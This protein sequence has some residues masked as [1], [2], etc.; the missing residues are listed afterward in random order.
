MNAPRPRHRRS[1][2][3]AL[4]AAA[5]AAALLGAR[6]PAPSA[7]VH[8]ADPG[9]Q[10]GGPVR[11]RL[12]LS[13]ALANA[14]D[15]ATS[16]LAPDQATVVWA[17]NFE[18]AW[19]SAGWR[20]FD[21]DGAANGDYQWAQRCTGRAGSRGA[22]GM[23]GGANGAAA[24]CG[25]TYPHHLKSFMVYGP[26]DLSTAADAEL[27]YHFWVNTH[28]IGLRCEAEH[29]DQLWAGAS[30]DGDTWQGYWHS[31]NW[32]DETFADGAGWVSTADAGG[33]DLTPY[34]G[35]PAVW[36]AFGFRSDEAESMAGG[37]VLV[38]DISLTVTPRSCPAIT[39][40][41]RTLATDRPCH[42]PGARIGV[43]V[44]AGTTLPT[45]RVRARAMLLSGDIGIASGE[46]TF[47]APGTATVAIDVPTDAATGD[48]TVLV[49]LYDA[50]SGCD[51]DIESVTIRIDPVCGRATDPLPTTPT[52]TA[53]HRPPTPTPTPTVMPTSCPPAPPFLAPSCPNGH[54][55]VRNA[56]FHRG[57]RSWGQFSTSGRRI[58]SAQAA[59]EGFYSAYFD[60]PVNVAAREILYQFTDIPLD[61]TEASFWIEHIVASAGS[62]PSAPPTS[63]RDVFRVSLYDAALS[64]ELVRLWQ[65]DP[66]SACPLHPN[67]DAYNLTAA[68]MA[69]VRGRT[70]ALVL[71]FQKV[72]AAGWLG[73][74]RVDG[75]H[76]QVCTPGPPCVV[77]RD[78]SASPR[79]VPPGGEVTVM[80]N[81][82]GTG[83]ACAQTR[84][85]A[86]VML[87]VDRSGSMA[88][89]PIRDARDAARAFVD[90]LDASIDQVGLVSFNNT[91]TL[92]AVL[93]SAVG[94]VRAAI[95]RLLEGGETNIADPLLLAQ[96]E[97]AS[98]RR[99]AGS[100]PVI[101]LMSD[102]R[103]NTG[104]DPLAA[105]AAA[106][107]A[108]SRIFTIGLGTGVDPDLMRALASTPG[109]YF[110]APDSTQLAGIYQQ[111][112]GVISGGP[113][114][115]LTITDVLSPYVTLV[116][117]SFGGRYAPTVSP[118]GRTLTWFVPRL[119]L[120]NLALTY[121]VRM[122][123]TP[124]TWPTNDIATATYTNSLGQPASLTFPV[125]HVTVLAPA[126]THP[127]A[128][129]RD[130]PHDDGSVPS[131]R[132][133]QPWWDSPDI[134]VRHANDGQ[135]LSQNPEVGR[136]NWVYVR[137][138]NTGDAPLDNLT[139]HLYGSPGAANLR[140]PDDWA[141]EI[142]QATIPRLAAGAASVV[143][144]P[145]TP[146]TPG[147]FCFL[148]R[149]E[150]VD[151]R[152]VNDG[153]VPFDNNIC[154]RNVQARGSDA[155]SGTESITFGA[156]QRDR[157]SGYS[158]LTVRSP[159]FP[160]G[161]VGAVRF[162]DPA[163]YQRWQDAGGTAS[164][165][166]LDPATSSVRFGAGA[167]GAAGAVNLVLNRIPYE[168]EEDGAFTL[169]LTGVPGGAA[170]PTIHIVQD[171]DGQQVGG[172]VIR[173]PDGPPRL[174]LPV[175]W[176]NGLVG[177]TSAAERREPGD[178]D[179][180]RLRPGRG[181]TRR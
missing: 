53:T 8:G 129:C 86:D 54:N 153:W 18:G 147:H 13:G 57:G 36:I 144:I 106:K 133:G 84:R 170:G 122:T 92:D 152:I 101:V 29:D 59:L 56:Y 107:A 74:V 39:A 108:G 161:G 141:P 4:G 102:G 160:P 180:G 100:Q 50:A 177:A 171:V 82:I 179:P 27:R 135:T 150:A 71:D 98:A 69:R 136:Q 128:M 139:V 169:D 134:W 24:A 1:V 155:G 12:P 76:F 52:A 26:I 166:T 45:Q 21:D 143:A 123:Q 131:N 154:Q 151:D 49:T 65:F 138:R 173:P 165:G 97:L 19:P 44:D 66:L 96:A 41:I 67:A 95:D 142:G 89:Q 80:L 51:Q 104:G 99:R 10:G 9:A 38:D 70:V 62:V 42:A 88:G 78:K 105:A 156:G 31:G 172:N 40:H 17:E 126:T 120:E 110:Y 15:A 103:P 168:G 2:R 7:T 162:N 37:G 33:L 164:G 58:V 157:G 158:T 5:T 116:P 117:G 23:G 61:A 140:W 149:L 55:F 176:R 148:A 87:V 72:T 178:G 3:L 127:E 30:T 125:P 111:I 28:C 132:G 159:A 32:T 91:A 48:H 114:T 113:A 35:A 175:A 85:P 115:N 73:V 121:R 167:G 94:T 118:D 81:V 75:L 112:A 16:T 46:A 77:E 79:V 20:V 83:G 124:G 163:L 6:S 34:A 68:D 119:G 64:S 181:A 25:A 11:L 60:G 63:G 93:T 47:D 145:W 14:P 22:W 109:D 130:H 174:F 146:T 90:R 43:L 137:V